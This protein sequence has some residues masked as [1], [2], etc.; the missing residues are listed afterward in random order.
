[1]ADY[2]VDTNVWVM[3]DKP[4]SEVKT[5]AE[6][7][8]IKTCRKWLEDFLASDDKLILDAQYKILREYRKNVKQG[9]RAYQL[10]AILETA[11]RERLIEL[12]IEFDEA[13][14]AVLPFETTDPV[15][16]KFVAVAL[17]HT[18]T[19]PIVDATD[20]HWSKDHQVLSKAGLIVQEICP[21]YI[22]EKLAQ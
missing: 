17:K 9:S 14:H 16:R 18:P 13:G 20:T 11:P 10:L 12:F 1:V 19:P 3:I 4:I 6:L 8:C 5:V 22:E 7:D 2:V 21:R 15:D